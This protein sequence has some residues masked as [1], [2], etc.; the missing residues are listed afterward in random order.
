MIPYLFAVLA[1]LLIL[2]VVWCWCISAARADRWSEKE[3]NEQR[4]RRQEHEA[5]SHI[6]GNGGWRGR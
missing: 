3:L 1:W 6:Y 2:G 5:R 4:M